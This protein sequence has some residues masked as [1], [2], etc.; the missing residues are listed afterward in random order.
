MSEVWNGYELLVV[1]HCV[2]R[3]VYI[4][5]KSFEGQDTSRYI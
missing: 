4:E 3:P 2:S 5:Y 1:L